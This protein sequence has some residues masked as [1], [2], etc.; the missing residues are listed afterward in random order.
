MMS[1]C[2]N[3]VELYRLFH[4]GPVSQVILALSSFEPMDDFARGILDVRP[5]VYYLSAAAW[6]LFT[7]TRIVESRKWR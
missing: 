6:A 3:V 4:G 5:V 1:Y 7:T 2:D